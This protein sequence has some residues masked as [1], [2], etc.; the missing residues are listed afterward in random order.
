MI[1]LDRWEG[2]T[3]SLGDVDGGRLQDVLTRILGEGASAGMHLIMTGDR[4]LIAG[5][6]SS[7]TDDKVAFRLPD[8]DDFSL[9]GLRPRHMPEA[10]APGRTFRSGSGIETQVALLA[11][12]ASGPG[13]AAA[14]RE[15]ADQCQPPGRA[16]PARPAPVPGGPAAGPAVLRRRLA[17][18]RRGGAAP[19][20]VGARR[21]RRR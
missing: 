16:R 8:R 6:I 4:S 10:I 15:I 5:R 11:P 9:I 3:A 12:D 13:Q 19:P 7:L 20:A 2:F 1:L 21:H 18:A 17:A 14:L